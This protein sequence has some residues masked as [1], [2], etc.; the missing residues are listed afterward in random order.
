M[1]IFS[2]S[3]TCGDDDEGMEKNESKRLYVICKELMHLEELLSLTNKS[4]GCN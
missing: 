4:N 2:S 3:S 1:Y